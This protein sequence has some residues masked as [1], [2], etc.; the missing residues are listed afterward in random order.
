L[1]SR[2]IRGLGL[3]VVA[4]GEQLVGEDVRDEIFFGGVGA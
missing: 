1:E 4:L 2:A 3:E